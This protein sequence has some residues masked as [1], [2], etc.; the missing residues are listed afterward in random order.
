VAGADAA[1]APRLRPRA[2]I[3]QSGRSSSDYYYFF[4]H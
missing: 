3:G 4:I 2:P 1:A